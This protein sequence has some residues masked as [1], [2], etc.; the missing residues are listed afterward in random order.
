MRGIPFL[1]ALQIRCLF[2]GAAMATSQ[3]IINCRL[4]V[5][6]DC[7]PKLIFM[8]LATPADDGN[9]S[10]P[11][12]CKRDWGDL[13]AIFYVIDFFRFAIYFSRDFPIRFKGLKYC[14]HEKKGGKTA[15]N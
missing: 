3:E 2:G 10:S 5:L 8:T 11:S 15:G 9:P 7:C 6:G 1:I 12:F 14:F 13:K 4:M